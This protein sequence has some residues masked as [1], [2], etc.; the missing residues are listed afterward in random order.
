MKNTSKGGI[1]QPLYPR[2]QGKGTEF[3]NGQAKQILLSLKLGQAGPTFQHYY[4]RDG[5]PLANIKVW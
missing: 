3:Q 2:L 4:E 5:E 1:A